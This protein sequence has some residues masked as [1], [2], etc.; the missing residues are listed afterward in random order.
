MGVAIGMSPSKPTGERAAVIRIGRGTA[1][2]RFEIVWW[3]VKGTW[4]ECI[5]SKSLS[6]LGNR[7]VSG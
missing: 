7:A 5:H 1:F 3:C 6:H 2:S 4:P